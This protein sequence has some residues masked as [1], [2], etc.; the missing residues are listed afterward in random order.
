MWF[1]FLQAWW[2][3]T[4]ENY[5]SVL[6]SGHSETVRFGGC[7]KPWHFGIICYTAIAHWCICIQ[8]LKIEY[9]ALKVKNG[10][11]LWRSTKERMIVWRS[12]Q[13]LKDSEGDLTVNCAGYVGTGLSRQL[14][15]LV[16]RQKKKHALWTRWSNLNDLPV[17]TNSA[18]GMVLLVRGNRGKKGKTYSERKQDLMMQEIPCL[19]G[20]KMILK[21]RKM[22]C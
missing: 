16:S 9:L 1:P 21:L 7:F 5:L 13:G 12:I 4:K 22:P 17:D 20:W 11:Y 15:M 3:W 10:P 2:N 19:P 8:Y 18:S 14:P 6:I